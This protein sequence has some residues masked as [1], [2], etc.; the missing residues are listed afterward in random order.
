[1][2]SPGARGE[3]AR[4]F[5]AVMFRQRAETLAQ[6][7]DELSSAYGGLQAS[8]L[9]HQRIDILQFSER[10]PR[11]IPPAPGA[12]RLQPYREG[13]GEVLRRVGLRIRVIQ[14]MDKILAAAPRP[15]AFRIR[16]R[17]MSEEAAPI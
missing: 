13:F 16:S 5:V 7:F 2:V 11:T 8:D 12:A 17:G 15:I 3:V 9:L 4:L 10:R 14:V 6:R 1:M